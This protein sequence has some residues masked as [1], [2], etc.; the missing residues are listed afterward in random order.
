MV[1]NVDEF[2][3]TGCG[4]CSQ[5]KTPSCKALQWNDGLTVLRA[6]LLKSSLREESK[7]G[8]P[9]YTLNGNNVIM[10]QAFKK[11]FALMFFKGVLLDDK[12]SILTTPGE[13]SQTA[14]QLRFISVNDILVNQSVIKELIFQAIELEQSG[15]KI[16][17]K[18]KTTLELPE[19]LL[20]AFEADPV[21]QKAFEALTPGRQR[22]YQIFIA[23]AK[24]S[25]TRFDRIEKYKPKILQGKGYQ[26]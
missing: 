9:C 20:Q 13:N 25:K 17:Q 8:F 18:E 5:W 12:K 10:I 26:E 4:R 14:R 11:Y 3:K 21:L 1:K 7:W 22:G 2:F 23:Q 24:Q 19:E 15:T 6:I 16:P